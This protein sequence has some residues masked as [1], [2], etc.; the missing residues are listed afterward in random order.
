MKLEIV[1]VIITWFADAG[2]AMQEL[3]TKGERDCNKRLE[4]LTEVFTEAREKDP[5][6]GFIVEC[7]QREAQS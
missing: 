1:L 5:R 4:Y 2:T 3:P 6:F 7:K